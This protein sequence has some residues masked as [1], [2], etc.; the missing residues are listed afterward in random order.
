MLK[1]ANKIAALLIAATSIVSII[2]ATAAERL[3]SKE[4]TLEQAISFESGKYSYYG[5]KTEDNNTGIWYNKGAETKDL[6]NND[7]EDYTFDNASKYGE[8][9]VYAKDTGSSDEYLVDLTTGKVVDDETAEE[10]MDSAKSKLQSALRKTDRYSKLKDSSGRFIIS[11]NDFKQILTGSFG[12]VWYKYSTTGESIFNTDFVT[13]NGTAVTNSHAVVFINNNGNYIDASYI[14]NMQVFSSSKKRAVKIENYDKKDNDSGL[15]VHLENIEVL[16]QDKDY[17]YTLTTVTVADTSNLA[18]AAPETQYFIQK[19][20][21]AQGEK[22]DDAYLPK[23]VTSYQLDN[24]SIYDNGDAQDAFNVIFNTNGTNLDG[25]NANNNLYSVRN[26]VLY[27]TSVKENKVKVYTLKFSKVKANAIAADDSV[28]VDTDTKPD[29]VAKDVDTYLVKKDDGDDQDTTAVTLQNK[30]DN[31]ITGRSAQLSSAVS[32]DTEGYTWGI[33][34]G[35]IYKYVDGSFKEIYTCDRTL[36]SIDVYNEGNLIAWDSNGDVYT[37]VQEGKKQTVDEAV[38][39]NPDLGQTTPVKVGWDKLADGT[40]NFYDATGTK[41]SSKWV[42]IGGTWY[43]LKADGAMA[44]GWVND[45]GTWYYLNSSGAMKTGW[46]NSNGTWYFLNSS[47]AMQTGWVNNNGTWYY[48]DTSG[49]MKTGWVNVNGTWYY[50]HSNG[51]MAAN[52]TINGYKLSSS[53]ALI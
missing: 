33:N 40:W 39:V 27:V 3:G 36:N 2:P 47:G 23:S 35:K 41:I 43:Y 16:A 15:E 10:K 22:K 37:T 5:Y 21:K 42:N 20:S 45:R 50:L 52:T 1:R 34:K 11:N 12:E 18:Y 8:K 38:T 32:I 9:Y 7:L 19:I 51:A 24:K 44:T 17:L 26:G 29:L 46:I 30:A 53:G 31:S 48:L 28:A 6:Y 4:G 14:A 49:A 25:Y 13:K